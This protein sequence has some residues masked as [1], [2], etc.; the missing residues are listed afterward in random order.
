MSFK[1][2]L[3]ETWVKEKEYLESIDPKEEGEL[4]KAQLNRITEIEKR[5]T[6]MEKTELE[7]EEKAAGRD[8]EEQLKRD[9]MMDEKKIQKS[10]NRIE[11]AKIIV[12][13]S[14]AL[15]M[16]VGSMLFEVNHINSST[17]GKASWRD[18]IKFKL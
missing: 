17:A 13:I 4:Y 11:V 5:L 1:N 3:M 9:Q 6:D 14:A 10:R 8:I 2:E 12:P 18:L 7:V 16:G 15:A